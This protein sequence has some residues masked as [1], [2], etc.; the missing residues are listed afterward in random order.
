MPAALPCPVPVTEVFDYAAGQIRA[1]AGGLA[2]GPVRLGTHTPSVTTYV[3]RV[4]VGGQELFAKTSLLGVSL[5]SVLRGTLGGWETVR[6]AQVAY[7]TMPGSLLE[8]EADQLRLLQEGGLGVAPVEHY[9]RGVLFTRPVPGPTLFDLV[10]KTPDRTVGLLD[11]VMGELDG[12]LSRPALAEAVDDCAIAER[13]IDAT[14]NRKFNGLTGPLYLRLA[15]EATAV[16]TTVVGRLRRLRFTDAG[17][18]G[19]VMF[20]DLKPEHVVFPDGPG[21]RPVFLD[22]GLARGR[23]GADEAKL[24][25]R[26]LLGLLVSPPNEEAMQHITGG[27]DTFAWERAS[28]MPTDARAR[29]L[30]QLIV[31]WLMDTTSILSTYLTAPDALPLPD[32]GVKAIRW[33]LVVCMVLDRVSSLLETGTDT[34]AV[35]RLALAEVVSGAAR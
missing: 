19:T 29:W 3:Q 16:L 11:A 21:G 33:A 34:A 24:L 17:S 20:G 25:S 14:F 6:A 1:A 30:R 12:A 35:W 2:P 4:H 5:V 31:L 26:L 10:V 9:E 15:G 7:T 28:M 22:P 32:L 23:P 8:R 18:T 13:S 27:I